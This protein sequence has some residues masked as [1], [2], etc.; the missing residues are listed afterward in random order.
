MTPGDPSAPEAFRDEVR[1]WLDEHLVGEFR[2]F[3]GRGSPVDDEGWDLRVAWE[4]ELHRSGWVGLSW[5]VELGGRGLSLAHE[6]VFIE[7]H[8]RAGAP[9]RVNI[10]GEDLLGPTMLALGTDEQKSWFCPRI[11]SMEHFWCQGFSEPD[12]GSDLAGVRTVAR[13]D[14]DQWVVN[15]QKLWTTFAHHSNWIYAVCRTDPAAERHRGL[16]MLLIP[17]D[18]DGVDVRPLRQMAD[19]VDFCEVYFRDA[20]TDVGH[21]LG[22]VE[23]GWATAMAALGFERGTT[24]LPYQFSFGHELDQIFERCRADGLL[25]DARLRQALAR[26]RS[27]LDV[28]RHINDRLLA[29]LANGEPAGSAPS[30]AKLYWATYHQ[31]LAELGVDTLGADGLLLSEGGR[32]EGAQ[33]SFLFSRAETLFGGTNEI[34]RN[35]IGERVLGLPR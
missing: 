20:V 24:M 12:A 10:Q 16:S 33:R 27:G 21:V 25:G 9:N 1:S 8:A 2:S 14:G 30:L 3:G 5:P 32:A 15:G 28:M 13:L 18:Q 7:E 29:R 35:I 17:M 26:A 6:I 22:G 4:H 11:L 31:K 19:E 23:Q 34:Q